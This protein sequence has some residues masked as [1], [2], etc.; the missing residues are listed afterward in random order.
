LTGEDL[1]EKESIEKATGVHYS[2]INIFRIGL[3][4]IA[5]V[6]KVK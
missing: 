1:A 6:K 3:E 4:Y 5:R 2:Y